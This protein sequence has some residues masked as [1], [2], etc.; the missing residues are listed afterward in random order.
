MLIWCW[1]R[2]L[3]DKIIESLRHKFVSQQGRLL[4]QRREAFGSNI[5]LPEDIVPEND[6]E[7]KQMY[8]Q[9]IPRKIP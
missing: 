7:V 1:S 6:L 2:Q 3:L 4:T 5:R 8:K 9:T